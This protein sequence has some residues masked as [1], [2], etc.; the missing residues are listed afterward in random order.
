M[1]AI[2]MLI[3]VI[4]VLIFIGSTLRRPLQQIRRLRRAVRG[5]IGM[6]PNTGLVGVSGRAGGEELPSPLSDTPC[7]L[8][9]IVVERYHNK[10]WRTVYERS[11]AEPITL[12]DESGQVQ[13]RPTGAELLLADDL[14]Q[15][16]GLM[17]RINPEIELKLEHLGVEAQGLS[18]KFGHNL[19]VF[20][21]YIV[22][23]EQLSALG[24]VERSE[25]SEEPVLQ[26][27]PD[28]PLFLT[29]QNLDQVLK[30]LYRRVASTVAVMV[31]IV[32][33]FSCCLLLQ[34]LEPR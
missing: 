23:G 15:T 27:L 26:A 4:V 34:V 31:L 29:D 28:T 2:P 17:S 1:N 7:V 18:G 24:Q 20:E 8:W 25:R 19:R 22:A 16:R 10:R 5:S 12:A 30:G 6:L 3:L 11:S 13:V 9:Q 14:R 33:G 21:R 32:S